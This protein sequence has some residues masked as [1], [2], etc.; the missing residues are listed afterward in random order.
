MQIT[1]SIEVQTLRRLF[2][3]DCV[4]I[5]MMK[6]LLDIRNNIETYFCYAK[7]RCGSAHLKS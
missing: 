7:R 6:I 1:Y 2:F 5:I 3:L 4:S